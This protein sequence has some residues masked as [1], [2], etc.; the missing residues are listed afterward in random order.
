MKEIEI[1]TKRL[2]KVGVKIE[3]ASNYPWIYIT[4]INDKNVVEK[5]SSEHGFVIAVLPLAQRFR[6]TDIG[7]LFKLIRKYK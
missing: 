2:E 4:K 1:F 5:F 6:F 7:E 3:L